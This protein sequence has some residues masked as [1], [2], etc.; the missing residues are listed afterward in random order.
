MYQGEEIGLGV[1]GRV[2][3][4]RE[5]CP[6]STVRYPCVTRHTA[7]FKGLERINEGSRDHESN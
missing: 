6:R 4:A 3:R 7:R 1:E 2:E 5:G